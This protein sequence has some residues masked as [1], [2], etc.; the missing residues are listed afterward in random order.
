M[1]DECYIDGGLLNNVPI[2]DCIF[3]TKCNN[4]E[5]LNFVNL[6]NIPNIDE[7]YCNNISYCN[8]ISKLNDCSLNDCSLNDSSL[9]DCSINDF[10]FQDNS[11]DNSVKI[12]NNDINETTDFFSFIILFFRRLLSRFVEINSVNNIMIDNTINVCLTNTPLDLNFWFE[13]L[14]N[15]D[16]IKNVIDF[17]IYKAILLIKKQNKSK[18]SRESKESKESK[19]SRESK[20]FIE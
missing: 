15:K 20:L 13:I 7:E 14:N 8:I 9:S 2:N 3:N 11:T 6:S 1:N 18:E 19:E 10:T 4:D 17:G 12:I 16:N 5:V